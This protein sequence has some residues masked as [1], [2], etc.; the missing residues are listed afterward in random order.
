[1]P[2]AGHL[3]HVVLSVISPAAHVVTHIDVFT[4]ESFANSTSDIYGAV[5]TNGLQLE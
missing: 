1:M 4:H 2:D 3:K 5:G